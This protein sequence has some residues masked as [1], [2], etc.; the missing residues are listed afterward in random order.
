MELIQLYKEVYFTQTPSSNSSSDLSD[1]VKRRKIT[2][3]EFID[4]TD[5]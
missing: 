1:I 2:E 5:L 4:L 3:V